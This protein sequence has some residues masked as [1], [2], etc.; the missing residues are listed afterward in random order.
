MDCTQISERYNFDVSS[1][2]EKKKRSGLKSL[3][4][5]IIIYD[6]RCTEGPVISFR[7]DINIINLHCNSEHLGSFTSVKNGFVKDKEHAGIPRIRRNEFKSNKNDCGLIFNVIRITR[8]YNTK[9]SNNYDRSIS[10]LI[11]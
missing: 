5:S 7:T 11:G 4:Q 1:F 8:T 6:W 9:G 3:V 10:R 2:I